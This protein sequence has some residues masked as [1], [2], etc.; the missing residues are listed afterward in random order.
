MFAPRGWFNRKFH[1]QVYR[2]LDASALFDRH[3]Y[4]LHNLRG[5]ARLQDPLWHFVSHG[6]KKGVSPSAG[7][8]SD[9]YLMKNDDVR[10]AR[11]NP[12]FH[13]LE[14]GR[15]E[16]RLPL[17][18]ALEAQHDVT[19]EAS[20]IRYFITPSGGHRRVSVLLDS[21]TTKD[22]DLT[23]ASIIRRAAERAVTRKATLR[24]LYRPGSL[25]HSDLSAVLS[26]LGKKAQT[27]L[28]IT[29][30][31]L[32]LTYSDIPF[33]EDEESIATS[34]S[35]ATALRFA[36]HEKNSHVIFGA[37]S[38]QALGKNDPSLRKELQS[39]ALSVA[40]ET[41]L[42]IAEAVY[43]ATS[44]D[45]IVAIVDCKLYPV[46]YGVLIEALSQF[47]I[48]LAHDHE[49]PPI[50]FLGNPGQRFTFLEEVQPT[51]VKRDTAASRVSARLVVII[52]ATG[53][54]VPPMLSAQGISV[55]HVC[56]EEEIP[57]APSQAHDHN[58]FHAPLNASAIAQAIV[59]MYS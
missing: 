1:R 9:Y 47:L 21:A 35:S 16:R 32:T 45:G 39:K 59:G 26:S 30:I 36:T 34:W 41:P 46:A 22:S 25:A 44:S 13:F 33:F 20:P 4:R 14:Y 6:W 17:R 12:L 2:I 38:T 31:P 49:A 40:K 43:R 37:K 27:S 42:E 15:G 29:E 28:E 11:L 3:Y 57:T 52:S 56:P 10:V 23:T 58:V 54:P 50:T 48:T 8:D 53:D 55:L 18:S 7:F 5:I 24:I 51:L 19:P